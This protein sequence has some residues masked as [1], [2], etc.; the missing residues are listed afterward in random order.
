MLLNDY[1][2]EAMAIV[3][4]EIAKQCGFG[5]N[6]RRCD[7]GRRIGAWRLNSRDA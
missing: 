3:A 4:F 1:S 7:E 2:I 6:F 5:W